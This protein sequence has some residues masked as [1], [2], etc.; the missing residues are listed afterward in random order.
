MKY[1]KTIKPFTLQN[2][3]FVFTEITET[4]LRS[5]DDRNNRQSFLT[6]EGVEISAKYI[7]ANP[8]YF[9]EVTEQVYKRFTIDVSPLISMITKLAEET[10]MT[11]FQIMEKL[12]AGL[13]IVRNINDIM[14]EWTVHP[15]TKP[16]QYDWQNNCSTCGKTSN[17]ACF[18]T[19][20]PKRLITTYTTSITNEKN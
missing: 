17:E 10:D 12:D 2:K 6:L 3:D 8:S 1:Y 18:N 16:Y 20:C 5:V 13:G 4:Y 14:R 9:M 7:E 15:D 11:T 19:A